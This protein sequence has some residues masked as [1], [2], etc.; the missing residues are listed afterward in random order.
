MRVSRTELVVV[1][2]AKTDDEAGFI[3]VVP[4]NGGGAGGEGGA[5]WPVVGRIVLGEEAADVASRKL[6]T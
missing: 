4:G 5:G 2:T 3:L 6:L 1:E